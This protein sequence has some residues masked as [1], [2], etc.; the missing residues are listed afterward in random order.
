MINY[1]KQ[2]NINPSVACGD[3]S[4]SHRALCMAAVAKNK[5][6]I[7][8]LSL[9]KDVLCTVNCLRALGADI[10]LDGTTATVSP[11]ITP[12]DNCTLDC[13]N[14]GTTARLLAGIVCGLGVTATFVGDDSLTKRPMHRVTNPLAEM[15]AK[16]TFKQGT[17]FT[18]HPS[19]L[20]STCYNS[21][22][23]SAQVKGAFLLASLFANGTSSYTEQVITR[24][25]T[26]KMLAYLGVK[27]EAKGNTVFVTGGKPNGFDVTIP[28]DFSSMAYL[29]ALAQLKGKVLTIDN[30]CLEAER[31]GFVSV[32][33]SA[34]ADIQYTN[35]VE[36]FATIGS[37]TVQPT[38]LKSFTATKIDVCNGIDEI[39]LAFSMALFYKGTHTFSNVQELALKE[40]NRIEACLQL[41]KV[42]NQTA[43]FNGK[44]LTLTTDGILP[45]NPSFCCF[46][47]HR[48]AMCA[49]VIAIAN[50]GGS[51]DSTPFDVSFPNFLQAIGV[52]PLRFAVIGEDVSHSLSPKLMQHLSAGADICCT[53]QAVSLPRS[54]HDQELLQV[55]GGFDGLNITMPFK[56]R[57][58]KL[59]GAEQDSIN[60][61]GKKIAPTST[62]GY[63]I[64]Q[65][66]H[67]NGIHIRGAK[68]WII[69]AG[70]AAKEAVR[71]L[72]SMDCTMRVINRT[73]SK[74]QQIAQD[75]PLNVVDQ[76]ENPIGVLSFVP[77]CDWEQSLPLP[78]SAQFVFVAAYRGQSGLKDKAH[79]K[80]IKVVEGLEMLYHQGAKSFALWTNTETQNNY[81]S[82]LEVL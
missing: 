53:Y 3:K 67:T 59:L 50:D 40:C 37:I 9:C 61:I 66:L 12:V 27:V 51:V 41:A 14:S 76:L 77:E 54:I 10:V 25:H 33:K 23:N 55:I 52:H 20:T 16:F 26:E 75:Y 48:I 19:T 30:V 24:R 68:L 7:R 11:I 22:V 44:D 70:G 8:N 32:L 39:S 46:D 74:V 43:S 65:A 78:D 17:L 57:V 82:F 79:K 47:D 60:T 18:V 72:S 13:G 35:V 1:N 62:D 29:L 28:N 49:S 34:G 21:S 69:G 36:S 2:F 15:G 80:G 4:I 81:K 45:C 42:C 63:G 71:Q 5:S 31:T 6:V 38:K 56:E 73:L 64:V 58:A